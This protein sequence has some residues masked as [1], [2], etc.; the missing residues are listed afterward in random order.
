MIWTDLLAGKY[1]D[2][3]YAK[4]DDASFILQ[5]RQDSELTKY[6]PRLDI[7]VEQQEQWL[8]R[9]QER[10]GDYYFV[11]WRKDNTPIGVIRVYDVKDNEGQTGS[12]AIKGTTTE[13]LEAKLLCEDFAYEILRI[14]KMHNFVRTENLPIVRLA[15]IFG[16]QWKNPYRD[17]NGLEWMDGYNTYERSKLFR[18]EIRKSL[19][20]DEFYDDVDTALVNAN[21][22]KIKNILEDKLSAIDFSVCH[23]LIDDRKI[24][25]LGLISLVKILESEFSIKI[26][27][28]KVNAKNFNS[29]RNM[30]TLISVLC[31][32]SAEQIGKN[33]SEILCEKVVSHDVQI[34]IEDFTLKKFTSILEAIK[35]YS[36]LTPTKLCVSDGKHDFTYYEFLTLVKKLATY[37]KQNKVERKDNI[38]VEAIQSSYFV[39]VEMALHMLGAVF[40]PMEKD[41]A[42]DKL[43]KIAKKCNSKL[44][45]TFNKITEYKNITYHQ[46]LSCNCLPYKKD[47]VH[48]GDDIS[49]ILFSTGTTGKEKGIVLSHKS[50]VAVAENILYGTGMKNSNIELIPSPLNHSHGLRSYYANMIAGGTVI[51][52]DG[53]MD[54]GLFFSTIEKYHVNSIDLVPAALSII[55]RLSDNQLGKYKNQLRFMEFGSAPIL[56]ED[57]NKI[58]SLLPGVPLYNFYGS[59]E[60]GRA[61]VYN[62]NTSKLKNN[63]IGKA[64]Q[65][66][67]IIIV[68]DDKREIKSSEDNV[69]L[70]ACNGSMCMNEYYEDEEETKSIYIDGTVYTNDEA[71]FDKDGDIILLGRRGEI[72]NIGGKKVSPEEIENVAKMIPEV[73]DC[74]CI[75]VSKSVVGETPKLFVQMKSKAYFNPKKIYEFLLTKLEPYKVPK[76]IVLIEKIPRTYN[77]KLSRKELRNL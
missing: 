10:E 8:K 37:F 65:N 64:T 61:T 63:C 51:I 31:S 19:Y 74:G 15:E 59:T 67:K 22:E 40:V 50:A 30:A 46:L 55:L 14:K 66:A 13:I 2:L 69:G 7:T 4:I 56:D 54:V 20:C 25:S 52:L 12:I 26:P 11:V 3:K 47:K 21:E 57:R 36:R 77:G 28:A 75:S 34:E 35:Y 48:N 24:D 44:I 49:E 1:V 17:E 42:H 53:V 39:A 73:D 71:Y 9:Q 18:A 43:I 70:L 76:E 41:C 60:A 6:L 38:V 23:T 68:D 5:T 27:F 72:I 33:G 58:I 32:K 16:V 45:V 29:I 62:F